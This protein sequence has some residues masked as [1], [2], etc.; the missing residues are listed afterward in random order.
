M[1]MI[2]FNWICGWM[3]LDLHKATLP[4]FGRQMK[5]WRAITQFLEPHD[6]NTR[7]HKNSVT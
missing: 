5:F 6:L 2:D 4:T 3:L 1:Q 7:E